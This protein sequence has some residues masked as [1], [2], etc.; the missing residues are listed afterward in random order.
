ME[1]PPKKEKEEREGVM[2]RKKV[3][4]GISSREFA[5]ISNKHKQHQN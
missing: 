5:Q 3:A 2:V 4:V 1:V